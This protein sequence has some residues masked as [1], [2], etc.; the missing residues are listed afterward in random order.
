MKRHTAAQDL[1]TVHRADTVV[2]SPSESAGGAKPRH[3]W[4]S[5]E[6][7]GQGGDYEYDPISQTRKRR[8]RVEE[9]SPAGNANQPTQE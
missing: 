8:P 2:H 6:F 1:S 5:D 4:L 7:A 9:S 3:P